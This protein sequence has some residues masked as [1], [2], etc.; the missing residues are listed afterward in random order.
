MLFIF[1]RS[2]GLSSSI[3]DVKSSFLCLLTFEVF[4]CFSII[5]AAVL[6]KAFCLRELDLA[7]FG[8]R[9]WGCC[10]CWGYL[11]GENGLSSFLNFFFDWII[12]E[13]LAEESLFLESLLEFLFLTRGGLELFCPELVSFYLAFIFFNIRE[14]SPSESEDKT[15][16]FSLCS[17]FFLFF[18]P[19][20]TSSS[21]SL[22]VYNLVL[23]DP[24]FFFLSSG[25]SLSSLV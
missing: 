12:Y 1:L 5:F 19:F 10:D 8:G 24:L 20:F 14:V 3:S 4:L 7:D 23:A 9:P 13:L 2:T 17:S 11:S 21:W 22:N 16:L 15:F 25:D 18:D 6:S